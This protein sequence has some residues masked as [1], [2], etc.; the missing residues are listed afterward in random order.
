MTDL[1][2]LGKDM[3]DAQRAPAPDPGTEEWYK[4]V[5][6]V[7]AFD[8]ALAAPPAAQ[9]DA[10]DDD[11]LRRGDVI[12]MLK[13]LADQHADL[14]LYGAPENARNRD[15]HEA[16]I[17][18]V[19]CAVAL[20][21]AVTK[22]A[23]PPVAQGEYDDLIVRLCHGADGLE[24][25]AA[26]AIAAMQAK[27]ERAEYERDVW[28]SK[29]HMHSR[30]ETEQ[31]ALFNA[32]HARIAELD[33]SLR[34]A[35]IARLTLAHTD[36]GSLP[37][38]WSLQQIA[39]ARID[40]LLTLRD[41]VRDTCRRAETAE[42][43]IAELEAFVRRVGD[44][45]HA[46]QNAPQILDEFTT[47][48]RALAPV[49]GFNEPEPHTPQYPP[50]VVPTWASKPA[51]T[52]GPW[53]VGEADWNFEANAR[54]L[55]AAPEMYEALKLMAIEFRAADLPHGSRA[56]RKTMEALAKATGEKL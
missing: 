16:A 38:D 35:A 21:D 47:E 2:T 1:Y 41:Q 54:L 10:R 34:C 8:K 25:A 6:L 33:E 7:A 4:L 45:Y 39:E 14:A 19:R 49:S 28:K 44:G 15:A 32:A 23:A 24:L 56:Y 22:P 29:S 17:T 26:D 55:A 53:S 9:G 51:S 20:M 30:G 5:E 13:R 50:H 40:D 31:R 27:I 3:R 48:A 52:P 11:L 43:R 37:N 46:P 12:A 42:A 36:L 18:R